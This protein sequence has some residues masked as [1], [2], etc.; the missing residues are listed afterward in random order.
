MILS[1]LS[2]SLKE[3][4]WTAI[5]I[6]FVLLVSGVFLGIQVA[7]W[8]E[9]RAFDSL[10]RDHLRNQREEIEDDIKRTAA[11][12]AYYAEVNA[13]GMRA[14]AFLEK[15]ESCADQCWPVLVDFFHAS[16]WIDVGV[17]QTT[18]A[19]MRRVGLPRQRAVLVALENY[20]LMNFGINT[21]SNER[22]FYR[23]LAR[24]LIPVE[25]Q[26]A[27][28]SGC[29]GATDG[30]EVLN[31]GCPA[32]I[33]NEQAARALDAVRANANVTP[34]LTQWTSVVGS[35]VHFLDIQ[36]QE[37]GKSIAAIDDA[38]TNRR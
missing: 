8:N 15:G 24:G 11:R 1:R 20:Y 10:E 9:A 26:Q 14:L 35:I 27:L 19:E 2:K 17:T 33:T 28:W 32:G 31:T 21:V 4:N 7:N 6:E 12:K 16:Q 13:A 30:M 29:H 18:F 25:A 22:P 3:Q 37:A 5:V 36:N 38:L 23:T 34:T